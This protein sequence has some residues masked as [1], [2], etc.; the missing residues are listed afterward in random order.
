M[1]DLLCEPS[2]TACTVY[3]NALSAR[4]PTSR[5]MTFFKLIICNVVS[6]KRPDMHIKTIKIIFYNI[7]MLYKC[8][9]NESM[10][11]QVIFGATG[12]FSLLLDIH[13][14]LTFDDLISILIC[15]MIDLMN[16]VRKYKHFKF[17][18]V[19]FCDVYF[20]GYSDLCFPYP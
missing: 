10:M 2:V 8:Q 6:I 19:L 15:I 18:F 9:N 20:Q 14:L 3:Y 11:W 4:Y 12:N 17:F 16:R 7:S 5:F 1:Y 13:D